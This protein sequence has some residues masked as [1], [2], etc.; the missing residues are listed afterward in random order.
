[1][2]KDYCRGRCENF[3]RCR[4]AGTCIDHGLETDRE[5]ILV[6]AERVADLEETIE[7]MKST[8]DQDI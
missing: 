7:R 2:S 3:R 8:E 4:R 1:M 5:L 6:L